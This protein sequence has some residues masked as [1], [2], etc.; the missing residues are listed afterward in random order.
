MSDLKR[1]T[2]RECN[3]HYNNTI[4]YT[5]EQYLLTLKI[6]MNNVDEY[7][8]ELNIYSTLYSDVKDFNIEVLNDMLVFI[9]SDIEFEINEIN[10]LNKNNTYNV[11]MVNESLYKKDSITLYEKINNEFISLVNNTFLTD[12]IGG[13]SHNNDLLNLYRF[14]YNKSLSTKFEPKSVNKITT[15]I[16]DFESDLRGLFD[17]M[18]EFQKNG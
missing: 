8:E 11:R 3:I 10:K 2:V 17:K 9:K 16:I 14:V 12:S 5:Y 7:I 4:D 18:D 15:D 6:K 1:K 13:L